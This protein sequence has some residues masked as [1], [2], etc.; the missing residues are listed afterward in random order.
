M[1]RFYI[2]F[3][4]DSHSDA[5]NPRS[6]IEGESPRMDWGA[7]CSSGRTYWIY[8]GF[9]S[10]NEIVQSSLL[11]SKPLERREANDRTSSH[12]ASLLDYSR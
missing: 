10:L 4:I 3:H 9:G 12:E 6:D 7:A 11:P 1:G 2:G 5:G 8:W